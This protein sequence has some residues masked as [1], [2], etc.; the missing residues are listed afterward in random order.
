MTWP[1][2]APTGSVRRTSPDSS[3]PAPGSCPR[4]SCPIPRALRMRLTLNGEVMQDATTE[5]LAFDVPALLSYASSVAI[6]Q[7]GD[8]LI[9][10]LPG[11]QRLALEAIP[12][13]WRRRR[14]DDRGTGHAAQPG[15]RADRRA[16]ALAGGPAMTLRQSQFVP[17]VPLILA[18][19]LGLL[20][21]IDLEAR[22][23]SGS[24]E[25]LAGLLAGDIDIA[26]PRSTTSSRGPL[27][28]PT[29]ARR[30][31]R[32]DHPAGHLCD[33]PD[34]H[35]SRISRAADSLWMP[36]ATASR[37]SRDICSSATGSHRRLRRGRRR[38]GAPRLPCSPELSTPLSSGRPLTVRRSDASAPLLAT[39]ARDS[40]RVSRARARRAI[41]AHRTRT[42]S[43]RICTRFGWPS[44]PRSG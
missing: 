7:P 29:W 9:T 27:P 8:L 19:E 12:D 18:R 30:P 11:G 43:P 6:L 13:R 28:A 44:T 3:R 35:G 10:G 25:Q 39:V 14:V 34:S 42:S 21:G 37:S 26:S 23:T 17:P 20:D 24:P 33:D 31:D 22:R 38:Q 41:R 36:P 15:A 4:G 5:D 1:R 32:G 2:S 16:S 40:A